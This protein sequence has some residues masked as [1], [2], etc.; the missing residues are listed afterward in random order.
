MNESTMIVPAGMTARN[1]AGGQE[2]TRTAETNSAAMTAQ[3]TAEVQSRYIMAAQRPRSVAN[4]RV[5]LL[6]ECRRPGFAEGAVY[7][8]PIGNGKSAEGLSI[9]FAES[10]MRAWGNMSVTKRVVYDDAEKMIVQV[11]AADFESNIIESVEVQIS[12]TVERKSLRDNQIPLRSRVNSYG[13]IVYLLPATEGDLLTKQKAEVAKAKREVVLGLIP[14]DIK[15]ECMRL[16]KATQANAD[17]SDPRAAMNKLCDGFAGIGV[18]PAEL[19]RYLGHA[20]NV[21]TPSEIQELRAIYAA[22]RD[23]DT[24]WF[25]VMLTKN[26]DPPKTDQPKVEAAKEAIMAHIGKGKA[27]SPAA[28]AAPGSDR[29]AAQ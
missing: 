1:G 25:D 17:A 3:S 27:K 8:K 5:V 12:K 24:T 7:V 20:I 14:G 4:A 22:I 16:V 2:L 21:T 15:E 11:A 6:E 26:P 23:T 28:P 29:G 10:A 18:P 13:D 9:R 19:E